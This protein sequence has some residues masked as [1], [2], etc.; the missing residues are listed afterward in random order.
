MTSNSY[1]KNNFEKYLDKL[2]FG[3]FSQKHHKDLLAFLEKFVPSLLPKEISNGGGSWT[4]YPILKLPTY[5]YVSHSFV[6]TKH[7]Y[8]KLKFDKGVINISHIIYNDINWSDSNFEFDL[9]F[10]FSTKKTAYEFYK[11]INKIL[12]SFKVDKKISEYNDFVKTT[13]IDEKS[14]KYYNKI[15][16]M[17]A[18][19]LLSQ[20]KVMQPTKRGVK[21]IIVYDYVVKLKIPKNI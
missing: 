13:F 1:K 5:S 17:F 12:S 20:R 11:S 18:K 21:F 19:D 3:L 14:E 2:F 6:F 16:V 10:R 8:L 7:P 9:H 4:A 15:E